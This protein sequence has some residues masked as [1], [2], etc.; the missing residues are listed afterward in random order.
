MSN[1]GEQRLSLVNA[2][3]HLWVLGGMRAYYRGLTVRGNLSYGYQLFTLILLRL[4]LLEFS[5]KS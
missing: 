4:D 1:T 5:R 2:A 3:K